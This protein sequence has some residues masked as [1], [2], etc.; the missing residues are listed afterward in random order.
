MDPRPTLYEQLAAAQH[1][2]WASWQSY[3]HTK[4][5]F[6]TINGNRYFA[7][8]AGY[9]AALEGQIATPYADLTDAEKDG[10]REQVEKFWAIIVEEIARWLETYPV[11]Y[12]PE[13]RPWELARAFRQEM[14][15]K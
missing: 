4:G 14:S 15:A 10:D 11:L 7:L 3:L 6:V 5:E 8:P 1:D 2:I 13:P 9:I 12:D